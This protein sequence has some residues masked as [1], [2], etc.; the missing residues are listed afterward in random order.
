[1]NSKRSVC[2]PKTSLNRGGPVVRDRHPKG[3]VGQ[4]HR[5]PTRYGLG[6]TLRSSIWPGYPHTPG[7]VQWAVVKMWRDCV[8]CWTRISMAGFV[9]EV[10]SPTGEQS[11]ANDVCPLRA[12]ALSVDPIML[13]RSRTGS[14]PVCPAWGAFASRRPGPDDP[15]TKGRLCVGYTMCA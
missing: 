13:C 3:A 8:W 12:M 2:E 4:T 7:A 11:D 14:E 10:C 6:R 1:M 5:R 15:P 9:P